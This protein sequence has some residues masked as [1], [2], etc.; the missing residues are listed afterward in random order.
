MC[1]PWCIYCISLRRVYGLNDKVRRLR[2]PSIA[3]DF[4]TKEKRSN[5][6]R[7]VKGSNTE[8]ERRVRSALHI[9]G[10]RFRVHRRD[11]PGRPDICLIRQKVAIFVHGCFWHQHS[12]CKDGNRIPQTNTPFWQ[13]KFAATRARDSK[14]LARL[15]ASGW[16]AIVIWE[17]ETHDSDGLRRILVSRLEPFLKQ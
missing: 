8:P 9:L 13:A 3:M 12:R 16:R 1:E 4:V 5:I 7:G 2:L 15:D 17:C 14:A 11:L 6:M 10:F